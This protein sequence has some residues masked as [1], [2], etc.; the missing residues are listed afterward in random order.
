MFE[1]RAEKQLRGYGADHFEAGSEGLGG[2][3]Q[4]IRT[5]FELGHVACRTDTAE[6]G[7]MHSRRW[8]R[9]VVSVTTGLAG[10]RWIGGQAASR[11]KIECHRTSAWGGQ[12]S[13]SRH[14]SAPIT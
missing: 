14:S 9:G 12:E 7:T 11:R 2:E 5:A 1:A 10:I 3:Q 4:D 13:Y 6:P 8:I